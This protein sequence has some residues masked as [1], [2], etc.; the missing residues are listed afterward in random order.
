TRHGEA[1]GGPE[2]QTVGE[3]IDRLWRLMTSGQRTDCVA[4]PDD[5]VGRA[6][7][8][9]RQQPR[10]PLGEHLAPRRLAHLLFEVPRPVGDP[11]AVAE[12]VAPGSVGDRVAGRGQVVEAAQVGVD[13][14][15]YLV[16]VAPTDE[17]L[18]RHRSVVGQHV[19]TP[20]GPGA[21]EPFVRL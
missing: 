17:Y 21:P 19:R 14:A 5:A 10:P 15:L 6:G 9:A 11:P 13:P 8:H 2:R 1:P 18:D 16:I 12:G 4:D 7:D 3:L 20:L